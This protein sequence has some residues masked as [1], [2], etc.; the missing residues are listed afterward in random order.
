MCG[1]H[2]IRATARD[3]T[4]Q[5]TNDTHPVPGEKLTFLTPP[6]IEPGPSGW[7]EGLY[8]SWQGDGVFSLSSSVL[9]SLVTGVLLDEN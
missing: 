2:N 3:N 6:G 9:V 1:Q 5:N 7:K 4:G 8:R